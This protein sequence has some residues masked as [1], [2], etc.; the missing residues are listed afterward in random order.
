MNAG[1][2]VYTIAMLAASLLIVTFLSTAG[3][4][5]QDCSNDKL[6]TMV[7]TSFQTYDSTESTAPV[8]DWVRCL[9]SSDSATRLATLKSAG[10]ASPIFNSSTALEAIRIAASDEDTEVRTWAMQVFA[11]YGYEHAAL[12]RAEALRGLTDPAPRIQLYS[13]YILKNIGPPAQ[14]DLIGILTNKPVEPLI[15]SLVEAFVDLSDTTTAKTLFGALA[16][17]RQRA[18]NA[19]EGLVAMGTKA[20]AVRDDLLR[21]ADSTD[22]NASYM[23]LETL[24]RTRMAPANLVPRMHALIRNHDPRSLPAAKVLGSIGPEAAEALPDLMDQIHGRVGSC[25]AWFADY[26]AQIGTSSIEGLLNMSRENDA[27]R[28]AWAVYTL[29]QLPQ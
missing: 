21:M 29:A 15:K 16:G 19:E 7:I 5:T 17:E 10:P 12:A 24:G 20:A 3:A 25:C 18:V 28:R 23:A 6:S 9:Q 22:I 11:H 2:S 4:A 1:Y 27:Y 13:A 8:H 14:S 26:I